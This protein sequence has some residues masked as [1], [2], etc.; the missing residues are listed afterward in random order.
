MK[1]E[2]PGAIKRS[3]LQKLVARLMLLGSGV[4]LSISAS[5]QTSLATG[6]LP[7]SLAIDAATETVQVCEAK[8]FRV[9]VT[10]VDPDGVIKLQVRGD[11]SPI[12]SP[13]FSFRKAY[14]A[15]D[16]GA[17][18]GVDTSSALVDK[19]SSVAKSAA[20][21][22]LLLPGAILIRRNGQAIAAIG[23]SGSPKSIDDEICAQA[24]IDKIKGRL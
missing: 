10:I 24:G 21:G 12:H 3:P 15:I 14:T 2:Y 6:A 8:G 4:V 5:A 13:E 16:F 1:I 11:G 17:M 23:V 19:I 22:L 18:D 20:S 9:A 7:L